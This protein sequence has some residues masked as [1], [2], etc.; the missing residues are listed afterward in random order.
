PGCRAPHVWLGNGRSLYD[1]AGAG[2]ALLR[3]DPS[4]SVG[5]VADA[6][7]RR[8]VPLALVDVDDPPARE[9]YARKL[10]LV[11]PDQHIAWRGDAEPADPLALIDLVRGARAAAS[12]A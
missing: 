9:L 5:G 1:A 10:A 8:G 7:R 2:F 12:A 6:A 3:F 11:R 4:V